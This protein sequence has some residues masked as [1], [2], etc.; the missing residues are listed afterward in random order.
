MTGPWPDE[1]KSPIKGLISALNQIDTATGSADNVTTA[2]TT[3][4]TA[5]AKIGA[6]LVAS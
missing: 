6:P 1:L 5:I 4:A 3:D 2:I